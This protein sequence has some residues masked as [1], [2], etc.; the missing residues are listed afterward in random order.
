VAFRDLLP[1]PFSSDVFWNDLPPLI[2]WGENFFR[3][4]IY[5]LPLLMPLRIFTKK[6]KIGLGVYL[7][8]TF[9][10]IL[11]WR[12]LILFPDSLWSQSL[13]AY[14]T[15]SI[16]IFIILIGIGLIGG[17]LFFNLPYRRLYYLIISLAFTFFHTW[18]VIIVYER[19]FG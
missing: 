2:F 5:T 10:Y 1:D 18:H 12:P 8:G 9:L 13:A 7:I 6:Q 14:L 3:I 11:S 4:F 17:K 16:T 19:T 15:T